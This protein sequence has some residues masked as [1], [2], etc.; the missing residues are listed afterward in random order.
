MSCAG[1]WSQDPLNPSAA[2][3]ML[4]AFVRHGV[5]VESQHDAGAH[6]VLAETGGMA[7]SPPRRAHPRGVLLAGDLRLDGLDELA[8]AL[9]LAADECD[10]RGLVIEAYLRWGLDFPSRLYGDFGFALW[11][12][13][14]GRLLLLSDPGGSRP[15][16]FTTQGVWL[17]YASH[18][19]GILSLAEVPRTLHERA[20]V[21]YLGA[22]PP[23]EGATVFSAV[24]RLPPASMLVVGAGGAQMTQY[25]DVTQTPE[26]H[27]G[28]DADYA[29]ALSDELRRA[30]AARSAGGCGVML[31]GGLDSSA[32][33]ALAQ[34]ARPAGARAITTISAIFPEFS[35]CDE[36]PFQSAVVSHIASRH[37]EVRPDPV[38][39]AGDFTR[40]S[41]IFSGPAFIGPHWLAWATAEVAAREGLAT[42]LTGV[43]GD[44]VVSHGAGR[45]ADLAS[46]HDWLGLAR[47]LGA[48][49][50]FGWARR[51][52]VFGVQ[53]LLA[54]LP[55]AA[56][57]RI[58]AWDPRSAR[59]FAPQLALLRPELL[60]RHAV[61][62]RLQQ[63]P[64]RPRS[65]RHEHARLLRGPG[66]TGDVELLDQL[67]TAFGLQFAHPFFDR[68]VMQ[69]CFSFPGSQKRQA[70]WSRYVLRN[71]L[72]GLVPPIVPERPRDVTFERP[73]RAWTH[74]WLLKNPLPSRYLDLVA[75]YLDVSTLA[76]LL[77][78]LPLGPDTGPVDLLWRC[79]V[80]SRWL[81]AP[82]L[83]VAE[84]FQPTVQRT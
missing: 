51:V 34:R 7:A 58:D 77:E 54:L 83:P 12:P 64:K 82:G 78:N 44:R 22:L 27:L 10:A 72:K 59:P 46:A 39:S 76:K 75:P 41:E 56:T 14:P 65:T 17:A 32:V 1:I 18:P 70:G 2:A 20:V 16:F 33:A 68:R 67:G 50:D 25:F 55:E 13:E 57:Q 47:E 69:L 6:V 8:A 24:R 61:K 52:R 30:V 79:V 45:F 42:V 60:A 66:R 19:R 40:L 38:S 48:V 26:R 84:S 73:F 15:L 11:D 21:D 35:D 81:H 5:G 4:R 36:R 62:E 3:R 9:G 71:A 80:M 31:S 63:L 74:A 29:A 23:E 28:R 49:R 43:D 37:H 53:A